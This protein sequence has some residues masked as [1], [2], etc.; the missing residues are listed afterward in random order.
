MKAFFR[1]EAAIFYR[2]IS[3]MFLIWALYCTWNG[4][5]GYKRDYANEKIARIY[6][7]E[8]SDELALVAAYPTG[9][10]ITD[11]LQTNSTTYD[12][13]T[14]ADLAPTQIPIQNLSFDSAQITDIKLQGENAAF[15]DK[16]M[17]K[18]NLLFIILFYCAI[19]ILIAFYPLRIM[20]LLFVWLMVKS[21]Q[22]KN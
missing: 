2:A 9:G 7:D 6:G 8:E 21:H 17:I 11:S 3:V 15:A 22:S 14:V 12:S 20:V 5:W 18:P 4:I 13:L 10:L 16:L 1:K 19:A